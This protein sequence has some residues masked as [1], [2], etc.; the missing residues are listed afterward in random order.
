M[1]G[2]VLS[3]AGVALLVFA[4]LSP[5]ESLRWWS[6]QGARSTFA[7]VGSG[8]PDAVG[9][10]RTPSAVPPAGTPA[11]ATPSPGVPTEPGI[12]SAPDTPERYVVYLSG[13]GVLDGHGDTPAGERACLAELA[14][15]TGL[16]VLDGIFPY[17]VQRG[18]LL[19][20]TT[21]GF[22]RLLAKVR[23]GR[24]SVLPYLIQ[25]RNVL[26]VLVAADPRYGPTYYAG[27][28]QQVW[29][30]LVR[31]G[32]RRGCGV[33][34]T[35]LGYSGGAQM[36]LGVSWFLSLL[37]VRCSVVSIGGV[38]SDD[39]GFEYVDHF[40]DLRGTKDAVRLA[41]PLAFPGRW[42]LNGLSTWNLALRE[43]RVTVLDAG[44]V[45][46]D[47]PGSYFDLTAS[48][49]DGRTHAEALVAAIAEILAP[50]L[51]S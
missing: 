29:H 19:Q 40:W 50:G 30:V 48:L 24:P 43:G 11:I 42:P 37:D 31:N 14:R 23:A 38:F 15:R 8:T 6:R 21:A 25:L 32:Y 41:G 39:P 18:G 33:P 17:A 22:W 49:P 7:L 12:V 44:P 1:I 2:W 46:H 28:A 13:V 3:F 27:L 26:Q 47:G 5:L 51:R 45:T 9:R 35:L 20:G 10:A 16:P 4:L 36:A 34:V